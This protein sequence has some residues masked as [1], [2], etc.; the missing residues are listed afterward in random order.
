M[1][2][3][4][5]ILCIFHAFYEVWC[6][7]RE[8]RKLRH[9]ST[10]KKSRE[11]TM[12][13]FRFSIIL[14]LR[15]VFEMFLCILFNGKRENVDH[16]KSRSITMITEASISSSQ[17][18]CNIIAFCI[19]D[20]HFSSRFTIVCWSKNTTVKPNTFEIY[21]ICVSNPRL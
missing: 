2:E 20:Q 10:T 5:V 16:T 17:T 18:L 19:P 1:F 8:H 9:F 12:V 14:Y 21:R 3:R 15:R 11:N 6:R 13:L 4:G 7:A